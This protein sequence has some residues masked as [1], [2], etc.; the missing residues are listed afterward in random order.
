[1]AFRRTYL[2]HLRHCTHFESLNRSTYLFLYNKEE[3][4]LSRTIFVHVAAMALSIVTYNI[5]RQSFDVD[6]N[7]HEFGDRQRGMRVVQLDG[8]LCRE[9]L[10]VGARR[11]HG[12]ECCVLEA[13]DDVLKCGSHKEVLL[14]QSQ[15]LSLEHVIVGVENAG[16]VLCLVSVTN[17]L[18]KFLK[19]G[20]HQEQNDI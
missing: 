7:P 2:L 8:N 14:L 16:D 13:T 3:V 1:M 4:Y 15:F 10:H 17:S 19:T 5:P 20:N 9:E 6:Q 18:K 12:A 11:F